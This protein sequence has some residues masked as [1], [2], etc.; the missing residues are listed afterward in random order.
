MPKET[1]IGHMTIHQ[2]IPVDGKGN[3]SIRKNAGRN[4][5]LFI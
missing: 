1:I 4:S 3:Q 5:G 2:G